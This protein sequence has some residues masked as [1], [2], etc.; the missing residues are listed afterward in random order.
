VATYP[1]R[2]LEHGTFDVRRPIGTAAGT[3]LC[4]TCGGDAVRVFSPPMLAHTSRA[5]AAALQRD[6]KSREAPEVVSALPSRKP[7]RQPQSTNP[8]L[9]TLPR[10]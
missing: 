6:E 8:V 9:R 5:L 7:S 1:Y 4:P 2:C 3:W 10:T